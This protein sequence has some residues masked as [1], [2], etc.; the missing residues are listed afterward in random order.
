MGYTTRL[1]QE[2]DKDPSNR[3][4]PVVIVAHCYGAVPGWGVA[5]KLGSR[6]QKLYV[7]NR[8]A[9]NVAMLDEVWGID[10]AEKLMRL[11]EREIFFQMQ[12]TWPIACLESFKNL[13]ELPVYLSEVVK[14]MKLHFG[15]PVVPS[16]SADS[17]T[18]CGEDQAISAPIMALAAERHASSKGE[19]AEKMLAWKDF[20]AG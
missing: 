7:L 20:T 17:Y 6:C 2:V 3:G 14:L 4:R 1:A 18:I 9:P 11:D 15:S 8:R 16:G 10:S 5:K 19:H 13:S 12:D